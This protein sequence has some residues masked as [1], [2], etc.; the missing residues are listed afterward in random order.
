[1]VFALV[2]PA[3]VLLALVAV[4][5]V[6]AGLLPLTRRTIRRRRLRVSDWDWDRFESEFRA[7]VERL[8]QPG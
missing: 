1:V 4:T 6:V 2:S 8:R 7:Y 5:V 3:T